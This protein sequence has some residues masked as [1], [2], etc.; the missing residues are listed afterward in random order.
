MG[1]ILQPGHH[2][3]EAKHLAMG[4]A[5][6]D[7]KK[8]KSLQ[9]YCLKGFHVGALAVERGAGAYHGIAIVGVSLDTF[10]KLGSKVKP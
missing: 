10:L 1:E 7:T 5:P 2:E 3:I 6:E 8:N 9:S 4:S